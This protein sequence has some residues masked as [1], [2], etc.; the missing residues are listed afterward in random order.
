[1]RWS[2]RWTRVLGLV[3]TVA[4][5]AAP[6]L[7]PL[8]DASEPVTETRVEPEHD[9]DDC[10]VHHDHRA[11]VQLFASAAAPPPAPDLPWPAGDR[12][13]VAPPASEVRLT[14]RPIGLL[15]ARAPPFLPAG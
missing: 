11:C 4:T 1:M 2:E 7:G 6:T 12:S 5:L 10:A 3:V 14:P 8:L 15:G 9:P 13:R